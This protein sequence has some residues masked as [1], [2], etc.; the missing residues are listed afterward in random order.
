[1]KLCLDV[2]YQELTQGYHE[3]SDDFPDILSTPVCVKTNDDNRFYK[4]LCCFLDKYRE[5]LKVQ[6]V[7]RQT[8]LSPTTTTLLQET[9]DEL[10]D[11]ITNLWLGI[12]TRLD[13]ADTRDLNCT[14][15]SEAPAE[16]VFSVWERV[17]E[18]RGSM[19]LAHCNAMLRVSKEGPPAGGATAL[20]VSTQAVQLWPSEL[21]ERFTTMKW[22]LG[23]TS[24]LV[25]KIIDS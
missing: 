10:S 17:T 3:V 6:N 18:G 24:Q 11:Y 8:R 14:S 12:R 4:E 22:Y 2:G 25:S 19:T 20:K 5:M 23:K 13:I 16:G 9:K 21:G 7:Q 1:M 15:F